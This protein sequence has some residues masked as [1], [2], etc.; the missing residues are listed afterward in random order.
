MKYLYALLLLLLFTS[1]CAG[2]PFD[3]PLPS[4]P[5]GQSL[6][7]VQYLDFNVQTIPTEVVPYRT[8]NL[9]IDVTNNNAFE[10]RG[11]SVKA[12]D[13]CVFITD[14]GSERTASVRNI[15]TLKPNQSDSW[16]WEWET[17]YT[18]LEKDCEIKI[19]ATFTSDLTLYNDIVV[20]SQD[21]YLSRQVK[22]TLYNIPV[23][24]SSSKSPFN[25][26]L[27][28]PEKQPFL[29]D[30]SEY[31]FYIDYYNVGDGF[32]TVYNNDNSIQVNGAGNMRITSCAGGSSGDKLNFINNKAPRKTCYFTTDNIGQPISIETMNITA[33]YTYMIDKSVTVK[34]KPSRLVTETSGGSSEETGTEEGTLC[35][36]MFTLS[37]GRCIDTGDC[38]GGT[39]NFMAIDCQDE[40]KCCCS[41]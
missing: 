9:I 14:E 12:Y 18:R 22:G 11:L 16:R 21:E 37:T 3:L 39:C 17:G 20:L 13:T 1:M 33:E 31:S 26:V 29:A 8:L 40:G 7:Q 5:S 19:S 27:T 24:K 30:T 23:Q 25:I 10:I 32:L 4:L 15:G 6:S 38:T 36:E 2:M 28:F 34:V 41:T 35:S